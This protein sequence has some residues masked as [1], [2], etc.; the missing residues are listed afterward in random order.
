MKKLL[1]CIWCLKEQIKEI[2]KYNQM[3]CDY[4]G[5]FIGYKGFKPDSKKKNKDR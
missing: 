1:T 4:C 2:R 5:K 3:T